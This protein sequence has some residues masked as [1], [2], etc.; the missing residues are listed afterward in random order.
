MPFIESLVY[1]A[2][3]PDLLGACA[4]ACVAAAVLA[5]GADLAVRLA[6]GEQ[7]ALREL[8]QAHAGQVLT[9]ARRIVRDPSEAEDVVQETFLEVWRRATQ[10]DPSRSALSTWVL[11]I[12]RSRAIDRVRARRRPGSS[13]A[14][15]EIAADD[16]PLRDAESREARK[17]MLATLN[18]LPSEQRK[19]VELSFFEG[20]TQQEIAERMAVPLGT[21]KTRMRLAMDKLAQGLAGAG[22][23]RA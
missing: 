9:V 3:L 19:V 2:R 11:M 4:M 18:T 6:R 5:L 21:V 10:Y 14:A 7:A 23:M 12:A 13:D 1:S 17:H 16:D 20:L 15:Q 22:A 8:F